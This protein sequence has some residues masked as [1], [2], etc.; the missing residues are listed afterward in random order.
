MRSLL[1][2]LAALLATEAGAVEVVSLLREVSFSGGLQEPAAIGDFWISSELGGFTEELSDVLS[3][4]DAE[5]AA[6]TSQ[7]SSVATD[8][9]GLAIFVNAEVSARAVTLAQDTI[10]D[11]IAES[12]LEIVFTTDETTQLTVDIVVSSSLGLFFD[13][14]GGEVA[15]SHVASFLL[16]VV[17]GGCLADLLVED[18]TDNLQAVADG[19]RDSVELP[20]GSYEVELFGL[21]QAISRDEG[22]VLGSAG[23]SGEITVEPLPEPN[24]ALSSLVA[25]S[26]IA[27]LAMTRDAR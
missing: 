4:P 22:S 15:T 1:I 11:A 21:S 17:G 10:A 24:A 14:P 19:V 27:A 20:P 16:C 26:L 13:G 5:T 8:G 18:I 12:R 3:S 25:L 7:F 9:G 23:F 6:A 2:A